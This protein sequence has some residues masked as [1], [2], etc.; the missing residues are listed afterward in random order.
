MKTKM[1]HNE[2]IADEIFGVGVGREIT[3]SKQAL[4]DFAK[5]IP[6]LKKDYEKIIERR[7]QWSARKSNST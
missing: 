1:K 5:W 7:F 2:K 6:S 3:K 4:K